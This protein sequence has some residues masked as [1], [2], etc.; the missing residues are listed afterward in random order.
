MSTG[1]LMGFVVI[2]V[3][4]RMSLHRVICVLW[5]ITPRDLWHGGYYTM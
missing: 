1:V 2:V 5:G 3:A 4:Y